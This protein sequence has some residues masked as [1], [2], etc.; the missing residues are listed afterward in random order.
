MISAV[1]ITPAFSNDINY[2]GSSTVNRFLTAAAEIYAD[3]SFTV[4]TGPESSGGEVCTL[5]RRCDMGGVARNLSPEVVDRGVVGTLIGRDA[6]AAIVNAANPVQDL[7][8]D[9]L[10]GIFTGEITNWSEVG[11]ADAPI[12]TYIVTAGSATRSVFQST[13]LAS[14][15]YAGAEVVE[16]DSR[17]IPTVARD[18]NAIGQISFSFTFG[19]DVVRRVS[20]D[21]QAASVENSDYPITR[22]LHITTLG[23]PS[24]A[25]AE[26]LA[27]TLS[28]EGQSVVRQNFV[29]IQ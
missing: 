21:G 6:I 19:V 3:H 8:I 5:Q 24:G 22:P 28:P 13:V 17:M 15:E 14:A 10:R 20:V 16:P 25:V 1:L 4:D 9:Q 23:E 2:V 29:G 26:F 27:W 12:N 7:S 18:P 11:G